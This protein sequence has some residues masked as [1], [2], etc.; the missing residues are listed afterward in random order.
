MTEAVD[1][2]P[3]LP[4]IDASRIVYAGQSQG[5]L[6]GTMVAAVEP[7]IEAYMLNGVGAYL[8]ITA[9]ERVDPIDIPALVANVAGIQRGYTRF[10]PLMALAQTGGDVA[11]PHSFAS[12]WRGWDANPDGCDMLLVDGIDDHT[13]PERS[14]NAIVISGDAAPITPAGW[15]VDPFGVWDRGAETMP[16]VGNRTTFGGGTRTHAAFLSGTTGH[17]TIYDRDDVRELAIAFLRSAADG[18]ARVE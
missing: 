2:M 14:M 3:G 6:I 17:F 9:V 10:H 12:S 1:Q 7:R 5:S 8:S 4:E 16:I 11:D 18:E 15:N 13:T